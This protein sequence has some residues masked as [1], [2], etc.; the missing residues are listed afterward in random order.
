MLMEGLLTVSV[1]EILRRE[2]MCA[3]SL[4]KGFLEEI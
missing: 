3:E 4:G 2:G 1:I